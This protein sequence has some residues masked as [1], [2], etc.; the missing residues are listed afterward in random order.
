MSKIYQKA[1]T[2]LISYD[3]YLTLSLV[4]KTTNLSMVHVAYHHDKGP[5]DDHEYDEHDMNIKITLT[6]MSYK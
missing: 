1:P 6:F 5:T 4:K 2:V 3:Y